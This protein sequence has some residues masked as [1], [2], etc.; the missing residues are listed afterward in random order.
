M[1]AAGARPDFVHQ[2]EQAVLAG[3][4]QAI[5]VVDQVKPDRRIELDLGLGIVAGAAWPARGDRL[6]QVGPATA[7]AAPE[8]D[9]AFARARRSGQQGGD[10]LCVAAHDE[11]VERGPRRL[12]QIERQLL[13][14]MSH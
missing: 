7:G 2:Y 6:Q 12:Q 10:R 9:E 3:L 8:V 5:D 1:A 4:R 14:S 11:A 13:R